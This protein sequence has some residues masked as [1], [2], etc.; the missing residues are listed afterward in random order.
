MVPAAFVT[1]ERLP[2][3]ASGK[4]DRAALPEPASWTPSPKTTVEPRDELERRLVN[5]WQDV[6]AVAPIG[7]RD[8]FF[9]LGGHSLLAVR[10]FARSSRRWAS[11]C[12]L[13]TLFEAPTIEG[14][15]VFIR[16][17]VR[18]SVGLSLVAIQR[19]GSRPPIFAL[20]AW[21]EAWSAFTRSRDC[22][23]RTSRSTGCSR[24]ASTGSDAR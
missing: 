16:D 1:L 12:P 18:P 3:A 7:V 14:Q 24:A 10:L 9:D 2:L 8:S 21:T 19:S 15:A 4:V 20:P 6:L 17:L 13:A 22:W 11:T 23:A 5:I